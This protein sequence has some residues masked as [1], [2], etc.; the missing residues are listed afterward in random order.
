MPHDLSGK[1]IK[2]GDRVLVPCI[3]RDIYST[4][5]FCNLSLETVHP[6]FPGT[7]LSG[8]TLNAKQVLQESEY[9]TPERETKPLEWNT[10]D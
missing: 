5:D 7:T 6:M 3:V 4:E 10:P 8:L 9:L 1:L 2:V